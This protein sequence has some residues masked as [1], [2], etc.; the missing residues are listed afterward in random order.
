MVELAI[1]YGSKSILK[2]QNKS[3]L[4]EIDFE[5]LWDVIATKKAD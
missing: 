4:S 3:L 5:V 1:L 2:F